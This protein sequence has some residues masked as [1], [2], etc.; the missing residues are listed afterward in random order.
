MVTRSQARTAI[1]GNSNEQDE[2]SGGLAD[3]F[4]ARLAEVSPC[5]E[6]SR[7]AL[8]LD[9]EKDPS[10]APLRQTAATAEEMKDVAE[11][12]FLQDGIL[13]RKWRPRDRPADELWTEMTQI[14]LPE[15]FRKEVLPLAH[16][17]SMACQMNSLF[18]QWK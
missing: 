12:Y 13:L 3:T 14:V 1:Q 10:V 11:G 8:I 15:I 9:Q 17:V 18:Q 4:F 5:S 7:E 16:E 6:F 2:V